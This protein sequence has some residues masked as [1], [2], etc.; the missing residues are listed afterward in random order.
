M[1]HTTLSRAATPSRRKPPACRSAGTL[2]D[3]DM[4]LLV[5]FQQLASDLPLEIIADV[6]GVR[7]ASG[8]EEVRNLSCSGYD[9]H[10]FAELQVRAVAYR[11]EPASETCRWSIEYRNCLSVDLRRVGE[12]HST[13]KKVDRAVQRLQRELGPPETFTAY[14]ARAAVALHI[15]KFGFLGGER[16][17]WH[18]TNEYQWTDAVGMAH[19]ISDHI[20]RWRNKDLPAGQTE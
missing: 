15:T 16:T 2:Q 3:P 6:I 4:R 11:D 13:L 8:G 17:G 12:M 14:L 7:Q 5:G 10:P 9:T 1:S 20:A 19:R 18:D